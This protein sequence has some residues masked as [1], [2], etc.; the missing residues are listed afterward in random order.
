MVPLTVVTSREVHT[1]YFGAPVVVYHQ[2][3]QGITRQARDREGT[4]GADVLIVVARKEIM[5][6]LPHLSFGFPGASPLD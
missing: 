6:K 3:V 4:D 1:V 5:G 2:N